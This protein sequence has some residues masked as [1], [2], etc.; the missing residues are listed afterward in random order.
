MHNSFI[1]GDQGGFH[2]IKV[3]STLGMGVYM[4]GDN[5]IMNKII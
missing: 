4:C 5:I 1:I 2:F 3:L